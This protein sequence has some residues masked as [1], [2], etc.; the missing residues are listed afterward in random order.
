[1]SERERPV[2]DQDVTIVVSPSAAEGLSGRL[3]FHTPGVGSYAVWDGRE[4]AVHPERGAAAEVVRLFVLG[5]AWGM[6]LHQRG[7]LAMH[8]SAVRIGT[9]TVA[10]CGPPTAGKSTIA[11]WLVGRGHELVSDDLCRVEVPAAGAPR[12]WPGTVRLK[13]SRESLTATGL[14][15]QG[16]AR[17]LPLGE[18]FHVPLKSPTAA[19]SL[20]LA[21]V[22]LLEWGDP[23]VTRLAGTEALRR[24]LA[25]A[26]YRA[27]ALEPPGELARHWER[28]AELLR[29]VPVYELR[30]PRDWE[31][32]DDAM[33][34]VTQRH[35][36]AV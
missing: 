35:A 34:S 8:A 10:F 6:L 9:G 19:G 18:K 32:M 26:T 5:S 29:R 28:C 1:L 22:Y 12:V 36:A 14:H 31:A 16:L 2:L 27:E 23:C 15:G 4:I 11:G 30:R 7:A 3:C 13:L 33:A 24:F 17:E 20:P 25:A 21:A